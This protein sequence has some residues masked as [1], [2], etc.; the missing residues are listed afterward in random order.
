MVHAHGEIASRQEMHRRMRL[1]CAETIINE[2]AI[3]SRALPRSLQNGV[4]IERRR[5]GSDRRVHR[6]RVV[7][8]RTVQR[9]AVADRST[10]RSVKTKLLLATGGCVIDV[11]CGLFPKLLVAILRP[12]REFPQIVGT[13]QNARFPL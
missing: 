12:A 8:Q 5:H 6:G 9:R 3:E 7:R 4:I 13:G 1:C 2:R 10:T 11:T